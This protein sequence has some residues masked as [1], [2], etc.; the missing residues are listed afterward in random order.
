MEIRKDTAALMAV[1]D[2]VVQAAIAGFPNKQH[3][4]DGSYPLRLDKSTRTAVAGYIAKHYVAL[5]QITLKHTE[6]GLFSLVEHSTPL[7]R[8]LLALTIEGEPV[9][10]LALTEMQRTLPE[11]I[12][13]NIELFKA[14]EFSAEMRRLYD[15]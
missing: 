3:N 5:R 4:P 9:E 15:R 2:A 13:E 7:L 10:I 14:K 6:R 11:L 12:E 1:L 8:P